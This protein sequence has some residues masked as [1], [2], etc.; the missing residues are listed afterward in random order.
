MGF[1]TFLIG[2]F[3]LL[4]IAYYMLTDIISAAVMMLGLANLSRFNRGFKAAF[5]ACGIFVLFALAEFGIGIYD[6]LFSQLDNAALISYIAIARH[7]LICL[8]T[9]T[10]FEGMRDVA[11][12]VG[13][14]ELAK[15]CRI[16]SYVALPIYI[17]AIIAETPALFT[18]ASSY[19][20]AVI[21][22]ISLIVTF[23]FVLVNLFTVYTCYAKICMP[24]DVDNEQKKKS[25]NNQGK[26]SFF[27]AFKRQK[28]ERAVEHAEFK[29]GRNKE[30]N[31]EGKK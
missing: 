30:K 27:A 22:V 4:D 7:L 16:T 20:A 11:D 19:T 13:L 31:Q 9:F 18:W 24:E 17:L 23:V 15:K 5:S 14:S 26:E 25:K 1:G 21:G 28:E 6:M 12:E 29:L 2:Y 8:I 10:S 3:L